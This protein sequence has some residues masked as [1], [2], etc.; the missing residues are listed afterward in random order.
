MGFLLLRV[1]HTSVSEQLASQPTC[2]TE[3]LLFSINLSLLSFL[4]QDL[5]YGRLAVFSKS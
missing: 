5:S 1:S 3:S 2:P 4:T